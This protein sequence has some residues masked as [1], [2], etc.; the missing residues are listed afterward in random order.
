MC[1][2]RR[3]VLPRLPS[4]EQESARPAKMLS[5]LKRN[6]EVVTTGGIIG[7]DVGVRRQGDDPRGRAKRAGQSGTAAN[8][9]DFDLWKDRD[10]KKCQTST[11]S[12]IVENSQLQ[13]N[14]GADLDF[15]G[16]G[17]LG[18]L[19]AF[20]RWQGLTRIYIAADVL[21]SI[22]ILLPSPVFRRPIGSRIRR[23][24]NSTRPGLA[25]RYHL[26]MTVELD[27]AIKTPTQPPGRRLEART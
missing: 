16:A 4:A 21:A 13:S 27:D 1:C 12:S 22:L 18:S 10:C 9:V 3:H 19:P 2:D 24:Q 15:A 6:D 25:G 14:F 20:D 11:A 23:A 17:R 26:L 5:A 7:K 8:R